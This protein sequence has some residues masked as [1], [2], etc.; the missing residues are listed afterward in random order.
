[1]NPDSPLDIPPTPASLAT[2][3]QG[4][5][6]RD[7]C[8]CPV[9]VLR[10]VHWGKWSLWL[11]GPFDGTYGVHGPATGLTGADCRNCFA[12]GDSLP[13]AEAEFE[14]RAELLRLGP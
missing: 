12:A 5:G 3:G 1:M 13:D 7:G 2:R 11:T 9:W 8:V 10:C 4:A 6:Q 14:R